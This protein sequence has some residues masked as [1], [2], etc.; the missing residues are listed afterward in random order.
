MN[1]TFIIK[2]YDVLLP[3]HGSDLYLIY[4]YTEA[5]LDT[6]IQANV[7]QPIHKRFVIYQILAGLN[8]LHSASLIHRDIKPSNILIDSDCAVRICDFGLVR[9]CNI[10]VMSDCVA[11]LWYRS[12]ENLLGAQHYDAT[13]D[14]WGAGCVFGEMFLGEPL[15]RGQ[16]TADQIVKYEY[17]PLYFPPITIFVVI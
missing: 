8:Y 5:N 11:S 16:S 9:S 7:L 15:F 12:P 4:E 10:G 13:V 17:L 2:L 14:L 3:C 1:S 6:V